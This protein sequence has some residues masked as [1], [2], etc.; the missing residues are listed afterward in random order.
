MTI[1]VG[2]LCENIRYPH[3]DHLLLMSILVAFYFNNDTRHSYIFIDNLNSIYFTYKLHIQSINQQII[4]PTSTFTFPKVHMQMRILGNKN[5]NKF[6]KFGAK[7]QPRRNYPHPHPAPPNL[8]TH[9]TY[10]PLFNTPKALFNIDVPIP[11]PLGISNHI[12]D[13]IHQLTYT[14]LPQYP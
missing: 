6:V 12:K 9:T 1:S 4:Q 8:N 7:K 13:Y 2:R 10:H 11:H 3:L 5:T 14:I